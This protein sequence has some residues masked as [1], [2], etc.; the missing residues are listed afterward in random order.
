MALQGIDISHWDSRRGDALIKSADFVIMKATEGYSY[1]DPCFDRW[2]GA[3][4]QYGKTLIG[5]YHYARPDLGHKPE[6]E[7]EHF[8]NKVGS[9]VGNAVFAL[10]WEG[11]SWNYS[12]SWA[13]K[14]L[15]FVYKETGVRPLYYTSASYLR[16]ASIIADGNYGLWV[17]A[18]RK[19]KPDCAP[20]DFCAIWQYSSTPYDHDIFYGN[21]EQFKKYMAVSRG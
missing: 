18:Y 9:Y 2:R 8:L 12:N 13:R 11:K 15:D 14:W 4:S 16:N 3:C 20:W 10:D 7:A 1:V 17:A 6:K 5:F 19:T 21:R